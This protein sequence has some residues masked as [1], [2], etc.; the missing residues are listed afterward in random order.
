MTQWFDRRRL[1]GRK[2]DPRPPQ[3]RSDGTRMAN[4]ASYR[5]WDG[6][7]VPAKVRWCAAARK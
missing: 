1:N 7:W 6:K 4:S 3:Y 5:L 2:F